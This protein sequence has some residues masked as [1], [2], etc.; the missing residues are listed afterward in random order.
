MIASPVKY[1]GSRFVEFFTFKSG[2]WSMADVFVVAMFMAFIGFNGIIG[3]QLEYLKDVN[4]Y[5]E[6]LT[7]NGTNLKSG[8]YLFVLFCLASLF[9]SMIIQNKLNNQAE[10][11]S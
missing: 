11:N 9:L 10:E 2:K 6:V 1:S 8:F 7:T 5:V 4:K 3:T